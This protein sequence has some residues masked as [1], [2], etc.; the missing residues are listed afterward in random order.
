MKGYLVIVNRICCNSQFI[1]IL[2]DYYALKL[3]FVMKLG[4]YSINEDF[5]TMYATIIK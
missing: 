3:I 2:R 4:V 1:L 5:G